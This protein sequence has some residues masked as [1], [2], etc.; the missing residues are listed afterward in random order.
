[1]S[2]SF[3]SMMVSQVALM[4]TVGLAMAL[5]VGSMPRWWMVLVPR[6]CNTYRP[7]ELV[8]TETVA[9]LHQR[10]GISESAVVGAERSAYRPSAPAA[11]RSSSARGNQGREAQTVPPQ[12]PVHDRLTSSWLNTMPMRLRAPAHGANAYR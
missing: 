11:P 3:G 8:G 6:S 12:H 4:R 1:M 5:A 7:L 10:I 2:I 9:R